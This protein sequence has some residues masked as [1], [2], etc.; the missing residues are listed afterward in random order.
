MLPLQAIQSA[1]ALQG[2]LEAIELRV[3]GQ[4]FADVA[5]DGFLG[6]EAI[7]RDVDDGALF[8]VNFAG[9]DKLLQ[10]CDGGTACRL[11]E[12]AFGFG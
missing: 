9:F 5:L 8:G 1:G 7:A 3:D 2:T 10:D 4:R 11:R 12:D 6:L